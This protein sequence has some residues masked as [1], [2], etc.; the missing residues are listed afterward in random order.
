[1]FFVFAL[2]AESLPPPSINANPSSP[3]V[4]SVLSKYNLF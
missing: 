4:F 1:M 3:V 2:S